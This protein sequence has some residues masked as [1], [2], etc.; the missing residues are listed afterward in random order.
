MFRF[1]YRND[2][3]DLLTPAQQQKRLLEWM[4]GKS[5]RAK[6]IIKLYNKG[7]PSF[8]RSAG[9]VGGRYSFAKALE[10]RA[11]G[12]SGGDFNEKEIC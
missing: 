1:L 2:V 7:G 3:G 6:E 5:A 10:A 11:V 4:E 8:R 9:T 12:A